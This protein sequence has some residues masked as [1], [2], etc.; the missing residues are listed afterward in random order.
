MGA[1]QKDS[2]ALSGAD[3]TLRFTQAAKHVATA[4]HCRS[5]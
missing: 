3:E 1:V 5:S 2:K 4:G